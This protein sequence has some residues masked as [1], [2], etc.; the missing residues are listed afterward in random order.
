MRMVGS[1]QT[2]LIFDLYAR[3]LWIFGCKEAL[4]VVDLESKALKAYK[5]A[6]R[7]CCRSIGA[8]LEN[9]LVRN[10]EVEVEMVVLFVPKA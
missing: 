7:R 8:Y 4:R 1:L 10:L 6:K 9:C 3:D 5:S 2:V